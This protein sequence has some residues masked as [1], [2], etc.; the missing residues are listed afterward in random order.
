MLSPSSQ[1]RELISTSDIEICEQR[2]W[3]VVGLR[4]VRFHSKAY[5]LSNCV[6]F[7][8][9]LKQRRAWSSDPGAWTSR[10]SMLSPGPGVGLDLP[11]ARPRERETSGRGG[12]PAWVPDRARQNPP[13]YVH[14]PITIHLS[15]RYRATKH[16]LTAHQGV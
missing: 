9:W 4:L 11:C 8:V 10:R 3:V 13:L 12:P 7:V 5:K 6:G 1:Y 14:S 16:A 2:Q 15:M